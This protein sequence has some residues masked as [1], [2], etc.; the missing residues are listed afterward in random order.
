[1][2]YCEDF[3]VV[4]VVVCMY[5]FN[6]CFLRFSLSCNTAKI[7]LSTFELAAKRQWKKTMTKIK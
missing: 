4:V 1:M 2:N 7:T 5:M 6:D 3:V